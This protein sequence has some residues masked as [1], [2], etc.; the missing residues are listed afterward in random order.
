MIFY[1]LC[2][3]G[4][5][6][7][8]SRWQCSQRSEEQRKVLLRRT[9]FLLGIHRQSLPVQAVLSRLGNTNPLEKKLEPPLAI[10]PMLR[11]T[12]MCFT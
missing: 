11:G 3:P 6:H 2:H 1:N 7:L 4:Y 12:F 9:S 8:V 10:P 5:K